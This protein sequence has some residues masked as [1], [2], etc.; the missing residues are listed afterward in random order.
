MPMVNAAI[1]RLDENAT[2]IRDGPRFTHTLP[3]KHHRR[4]PFRVVVEKRASLETTRSGFSGIPWEMLT[5]AGRRIQVERMPWIDR[6]K[7]PPGVRH[8]PERPATRNPS[9]ATPPFPPTPCPR[10][11]LRA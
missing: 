11:A 3:T 7:Q 9:K 6:R 4:P 2:G 5:Q 1:G 10:V 8:Q